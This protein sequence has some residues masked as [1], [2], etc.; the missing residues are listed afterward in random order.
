MIPLKDIHLLYFLIQTY[1]LLTFNNGEF[2]SR[3]TYFQAMESE[4]GRTGEL[5]AAEE[6]SD[7]RADQEEDQEA[8]EVRQRLR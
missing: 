5:V 4:E 2:I 8:G 7:H 3:N 1:Q 6:R